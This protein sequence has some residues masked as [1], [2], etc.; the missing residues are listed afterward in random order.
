MLTEREGETGV[1]GAMRAMSWA[2]WNGARDI[3][4]GELRQHI[5]AIFGP[6]VDEALQ[7]RFMGDA[8]HVPAALPED[9]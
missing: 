6:Q 9:K 4:A 7:R 5:L 8:D 2:L 1:E 3:K